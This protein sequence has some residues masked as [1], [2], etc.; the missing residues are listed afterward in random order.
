MPKAPLLVEAGTAGAE[1]QPAVAHDVEHGGAFGD[2]DR[3]VERVR[4]QHHAVADAHPL[5]RA[6]TAPRK[7]SG[8]EECENSVEEVMLH[9]P[10]RVEAHRIGELRLRQRLPVALVLAARVP[11]LEH[12][13]LVRAD[14]S[15]CAPS[16]WLRR[17][18]TFGAVVV[19]R[20]AAAAALRRSEL[21]AG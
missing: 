6:A 4:Q 20:G 14:R 15:S 1:L 5:V 8:A 17:L 18:N 2:A 19:K 13:H 3:M 7:T 11:R 21:A 16:Q 10:Q 9:L 12:L